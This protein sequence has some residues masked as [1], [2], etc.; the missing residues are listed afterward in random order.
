MNEVGELLRDY[1]SIFVGSMFKFVGGPL[2][3]AKSDVSIVETTI[4][5][6]LGMITTIFIIT[7]F[8]DGLRKRLIIRNQKKRN[9]RVFTPKKRRLIRIYKKFGIRGI[10]FL[11]PLIFSPILGGIL[12]I[13]FGAP[14]R[15]IML[16]MFVSA[17]FWGLVLSTFF[18]QIGNI[19]FRQLF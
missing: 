8:G 9:Y 19:N 14:P 12:A 15:K 5:S 3:G 2:I 16:Y 18:T 6:A 13:S 11:T 17:L 1:F 4:I 10:A 7:F